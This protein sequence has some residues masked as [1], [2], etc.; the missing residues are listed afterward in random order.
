MPVFDRTSAYL[1][2]ALA[3]PAAI[4]VVGD[5]IEEPRVV[6]AGLGL[7]VVVLVWLLVNALRWSI[8][9]RPLRARA[10]PPTPSDQVRPTLGLV[11]VSVALVAVVAVMLAILR[12]AELD[13]ASVTALASA[14]FGVIGTL[15]GGFVGAHVTGAAATSAA[16]AGAAAVTA[17]THTPTSGSAD[18]PTNIGGA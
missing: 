18:E 6:R 9:Q 17:A 13:D 5:A 16:A 11:A 14:A 15:V 1:F 4:A 2:I 10:T 3:G 8:S 7:L 12:R